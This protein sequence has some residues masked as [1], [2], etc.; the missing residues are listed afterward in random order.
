MFNSY[1]YA[2]LVGLVL[3]GYSFGAGYRMGANAEI[4][5]CTKVKTSFNRAMSLE[6]EKMESKQRADS[7]A[8]DEQLK[9]TVKQRDSYRMATEELNKQL[10]K[11]KQ[12]RDQDVYKEAVALYESMDKCATGAIPDRYK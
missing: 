7:L 3:A 1:V 8:K 2:I 6:K 11:I 5:N 4:A 12:T 9:V 10:K